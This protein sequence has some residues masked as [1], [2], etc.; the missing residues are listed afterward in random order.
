VSGSPSLLATSDRSSSEI[1]TR[2][3]PVLIK[4]RVKWLPHTDSGKR[5]FCL[6]YVRQWDIER[7]ATYAEA[8]WWQVGR[9]LVFVEQLCANRDMYNRLDENG[10]RS[11][12]LG[13]MD[14]LYSQRGIVETRTITRVLCC[15]AEASQ[16]LSAL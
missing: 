9:Y 1:P 13:A 8:F 11:V 14:T 5:N 3:K 7:F 2:S 10:T 16:V 15:E 4:H 12:D 6:Y